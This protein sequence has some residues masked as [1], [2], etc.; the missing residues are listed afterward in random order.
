MGDVYSQAHFNIA[1][2]ASSDGSGGLYHHENSLAINPCLIKVTESDRQISRTFLCYQE[3]FWNEK[4]ENGP[5]R[6]RGWVLQER[7]LSPRVVCLQSNFLGVWRDDSSGI[8]AIE[9]YEMGS[10]VEKFENFTSTCG[11]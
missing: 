1:T 6:K 11:R 7:I 5:L 2:T 4:V 8:S 9:L 3:T 10:G